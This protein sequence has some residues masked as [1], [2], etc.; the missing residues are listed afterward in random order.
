MK[1]ERYVLDR[2]MHTRGSYFQTL[3]CLLLDPPI[4]YI[5]V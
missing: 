1:G 5:T 2:L 3:K 4:F